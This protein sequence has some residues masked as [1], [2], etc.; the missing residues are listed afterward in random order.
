MLW[1]SRCQQRTQL[2]LRLF[3]FLY[4]AVVGK[5]AVNKFGAC[6]QWRG[7]AVN[8]LKKQEGCFNP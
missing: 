7:E 5:G 1:E 8:L 3:F 6:P 4:H 2:K